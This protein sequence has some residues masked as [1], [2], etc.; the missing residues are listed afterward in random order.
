MFPIY[1]GSAFKYTYLY[2]AFPLQEKGTLTLGLKCDKYTASNW[3]CF[4]NFSLLYQPL[5]DFYDGLEAVVKPT[6]KKEH[7]SYD[8]SGRKIGDD[9]SSK[10][11][12]IRNGK[13][14]L[15]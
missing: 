9:D 13:K 8:L 15:N 1:L 5:P 6:L 12:V 4:D 3:C 14:V 2:L 11:I 7:S 10:G